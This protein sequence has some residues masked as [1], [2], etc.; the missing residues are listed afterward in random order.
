MASVDQR[1]ATFNA[2]L[3]SV[4]ILARERYGDVIML[5]PLIAA[6]KQQHPSASIYIVAFTKMVFD[7]FIHDTNISGVFHAKRDL[8]RYLLRFLPKKYDLLFNSKDH[9]ST[10]FLLQ[11]RLVRARFKVGYRGNGNEALFDRLLEVPRGTHESQRNLELLKAIGGATPQAAKPYIPEMPVSAGID[12]FIG[13]MPRNRFI[14]IN[15]SAGTP[16][17][18]RTFE[19]WSD[20]IRSFPD[21]R[22]VIISSPGDLKAKQEL[23]A[24]HPNVF[25][26]PSTKN[27]YE[28][29]KL[30]DR[31]KLLVTPDTSLVHV[32]ACSD[33]PVVALYRHNPDDSRLFA[34]LSTLQEVLTSPTQEVMDIDN[35]SVITA[36]SRM[37][38]GIE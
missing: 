26:S 31:L 38:T 36:V 37:V 3:K 28:V 6:L 20:L 32:A 8:G 13:M 23:E 18:N 27:L 4:V 19:Q 30:L 7:F 9:K 2:P 1:N 11:S 33:K 16:G 34:P 24:P 35:A 14:G 17:G 15:I 22:F 10:H 29:W 25:A 21:E 5:T 12:A